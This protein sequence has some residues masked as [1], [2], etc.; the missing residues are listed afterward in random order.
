MPE[1]PEST[2]RLIAPIAVEYTPPP[3]TRTDE[4]I[5]R[6]LL[7]V[8]EDHGLNG[9]NIR[10]ENGLVRVD[11]TEPYPLGATGSI[12]T[13]QEHQRHSHWEPILYQ[14]ELGADVMAMTVPLPK[15]YAYKGG[16]ARWLLQRELG[17]DFEPSPSDIDIIKHGRPESE[18]GRE[19]DPLFAILAPDD[20]VR[21]IK[22]EVVGSLE[23]HVYKVEF[24][25]NE[26]LATNHELI[27]TPQCVI[28]NVQGVIRVS[29]YEEA[30]GGVRNS[31]VARALRFYTQKMCRG[32]MP[33]IK[34]IP[35]E[36]L[37][38]PH[39]ESFGYCSQLDRMARDGYPHETIAFIRVL[40]TFGHLPQK[41]RSVEEA[42][43]YFYSHLPDGKHY[44]FLNIFTPSNQAKIGLLPEW[45]Y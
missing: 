3:E 5:S 40:R 6:F 44:E 37:Y 14:P 4:E 30:N 28:D 2:E 29:G 19:E 34:G 24:A 38:E 33:T 27:A 18:Q 8:I 23:T 10:I 26:V 42:A 7:E 16:T 17:L 15:E 13:F 32:E 31:V 45:D 43:E 21:G 39:P 20:A 36:K 9:E 41:T 25:M 22:M 35:E 12:E 11:L 1:E